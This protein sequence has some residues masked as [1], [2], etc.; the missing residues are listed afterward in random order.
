MMI[1]AQMFCGFTRYFGLVKQTLV[2]PGGECVN[3]R[4]VSGQ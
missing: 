1:G 4:V 3:M 2:K